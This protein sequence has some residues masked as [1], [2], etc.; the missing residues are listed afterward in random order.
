M[1]NH[2]RKKRYNVE[3]LLRKQLT[4]STKI[5]DANLLTVLA[6]VLSIVF[7]WFD[8]FV[9]AHITY[10]YLLLGTYA[11]TFRADYVTLF[12]GLGIDEFEFAIGTI[13]NN[14]L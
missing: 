8:I 14:I 11:A 1:P 9:L 4:P 6:K 3:H 2:L 13:V 12:V 7:L 5:L 10:D